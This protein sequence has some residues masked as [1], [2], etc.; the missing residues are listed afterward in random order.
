MNYDAV[1]FDMD[2]LLLDTERLYSEGIGQLV[3]QYGK[4][5]DWSVKE[6]VMGRPSD[7]VA[8]FLVQT[9]DLPITPE[10]Y[11]VQRDEV[12]NALFVNANAKPGA[13]ALVRRLS[14]GGVPMAVA[15]GS[16]R[17]LLELKTTRH[18]DWFALFNTVVSA[19]DD[20]VARG[21][22]APDV[23]LTAAAK[24]DVDPARCVVFEDSPAGAH[25]GVA[26][27]MGVIAIPDPRTNRALFPNAVTYLESLDVFRPEDWGL[28]T[29]S[30]P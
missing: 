25:A 21:K 27:A 17:P 11:M 10:D 19:E 26:A 6:Q 5:Y 23:F 16:S 15:T 7:E 24:L 13:E 18:R 8:R 20:D 3:A 2:G 9:L 30:A 14:D 22:P 29:G 4:R 28:M 12:L 1:I